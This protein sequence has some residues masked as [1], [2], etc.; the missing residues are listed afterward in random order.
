[1]P[2]GNARVYARSLGAEAD[3]FRIV[4]RLYSFLS[5]GADFPALIFYHLFQFLDIADGLIYLQTREPKIIH[6]GLKAVCTDAH[7][8]FPSQ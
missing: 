4:S 1:M 2:N 6:G 5:I 8:L 3:C 7:D